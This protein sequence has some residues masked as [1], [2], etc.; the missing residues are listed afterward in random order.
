MAGLIAMS[1]AI[2]S[3]QT[4]K[5]CG[6]EYNTNYK[7]G[8]CSERCY[9]KK[10]GQEILD[11]IRHKHF[12]CGSCFAVIKDIEHKPEQYDLLERGSALTI[13]DGEKKRV[14]YTQA[15]TEKAII[16]FQYLTDKADKGEFGTEC[17]CGTVDHYAEEPI[18]RE[19]EPYAWNLNLAC[20]T[21]AEQGH[22]DLEE[23]GFDLVQFL[24]TYWES[25]DLAY[26]V[27]QAVY[28]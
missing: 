21:L 7:R 24:N 3:R 4:C 27:G 8:Y 23:H 12:L 6:D 2:H 10:R 25:E 1:H 15:E 9:L 5:T 16:G 14:R 20:E 19:I 22:S 13:E 28:R 11:T 18:N 26:A 17:L